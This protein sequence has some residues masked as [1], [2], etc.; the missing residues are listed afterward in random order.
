[1]RKTGGDDGIQLIKLSGDA[2]A[3]LHHLTGDTFLVRRHS[4]LWYFLPVQQGE[5]GGG[6]N[7]GYARE[8]EAIKGKVGRAGATFY[9]VE[10]CVI[11]R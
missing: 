11:Q 1:M 7:S 9:V 5:E 4:C 8:E 3:E 10:M 2:G 6:G